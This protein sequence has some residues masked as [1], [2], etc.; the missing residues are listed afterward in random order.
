MICNS[1]LL[2]TRKIKELVTGGGSQT[3]NDHSTNTNASSSNNIS[4]RNIPSRSLTLK[5][6]SSEPHCSNK[7]DDKQNSLTK[8]SK[9]VQIS[10]SLR[11]PRT[12]ETS[13][14]FTNGKQN[15]NDS[16]TTTQVLKQN[17]TKIIEH[18]NTITNINQNRNVTT[19]FETGYSARYLIQDDFNSANNSTTNYEKTESNNIVQVSNGTRIYQINESSGKNLDN[20]NNQDGINFPIK[21]KPFTMSVE[22]LR[23]YFPEI[24]NTRNDVSGQCQNLSEYPLVQESCFNESFGELTRKKKKPCTSINC[25]S[26][27]CS[28]YKDASEGSISVNTESPKFTTMQ[29]TSKRVRKP[30]MLQKFYSLDRGYKRPSFKSN[31]PPCEK[32]PDYSARRYDIKIR[33]NICSEQDTNILSSDQQ[34]FLICRPPTPI[35]N[36]CT[37]YSSSWNS[38]NPNHIF[39][40]SSLDYIN[41]A[42]SFSRS[43][44]P[45]VHISISDQIEK[46]SSENGNINKSTIYVLNNGS[47][48]HVEY[49]NLNND[50]RYANTN[51][52][53]FI[54]KD[55]NKTISE[56]IKDICDDISNSRWKT[57]AP[58]SHTLPKSCK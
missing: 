7:K 45:K 27:H 41:G 47:T 56:D 18:Q 53:H 40:N 46:V 30:S 2:L 28:H 58:N 31:S 9:P 35:H 38:D 19:K 36:N 6:I 49:S 8:K 55:G 5:P 24:K 57:E 17:D 15:S 21:N 34:R 44:V 25:N 14:E 22:D 10:R 23:S 16:Q 4:K 54:K 39:D 12:V 29:A 11:N 26:V 37:N 42:R 52:E 43:H 33:K 20:E 48:E 51:G 50:I 3:S 1:G 32:S 13:V